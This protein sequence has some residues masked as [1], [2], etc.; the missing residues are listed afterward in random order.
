[1]DF[2]RDIQGAINGRQEWYDPDDAKQRFR[3]T[4]R[5]AATG[6][7]LLKTLLSRLPTD[8]RKR[9]DSILERP[10]FTRADLWNETKDNA[11]LTQIHA[12]LNEQSHAHLVGA[13]VHAITTAETPVAIIDEQLQR[14]M[15]FAQDR[16][17]VNEAF[18]GVERPI[19][20]TRLAVPEELASRF[21]EAL[22][23]GNSAS[24]TAPA[25]SLLS[26]LTVG[27]VIELKT[28]AHKTIFEVALR[29]TK[30][31][32]PESFMAQYVPACQEYLG[33][34]SQRIASWYPDE[35]RQCRR[36]K[37]ALLWGPAGCGIWRLLDERE[38]SG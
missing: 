12:F 7:T 23:S 10:Y 24:L 15:V 29:S 38:K 37:M 3:D 35:F 30:W 21:D 27:Q 20:K 31:P 1:M 13:G 19:A 25:L 18:R 6:E 9:Y 5:K 14:E 33:Q 8:A 34:I 32:S 26:L 11:E 4:I 36:D 2:A 22:Q 16:G 28:A 17:C